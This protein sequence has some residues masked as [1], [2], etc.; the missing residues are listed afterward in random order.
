MFNSQKINN[1]P[2]PYKVTGGSYT[3][4][5]KDLFTGKYDPRPE[6]DNNPN[7]ILEYFRDAMSSGEYDAIALATIWESLIDT[8]YDWEEDGLAPT[9][10]QLDHAYKVL[11]RL[12]NISRSIPGSEN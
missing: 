10:E 1:D 3:R 11:T 5:D 4:C 9:L 2:H 7:P 6:Y 12:V 8:G